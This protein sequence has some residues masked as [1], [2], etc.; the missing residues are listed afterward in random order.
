MQGSEDR[1]ILAIESSLPKPWEVEATF[2][3]TLYEWMSRAP[4]L[5]I[6]GAAHLLLFFLL[7]A[8]P[9]DLLQKREEQVIQTALQPQE[10]IPFEPPP[11]EIPPEIDEEEL[12]DEPVLQDESVEQDDVVEDLDQQLSEGD[13]EDLFS[14]DFDVAE[15]WNDVLGIG[16]GGPPG[17]VRPAGKRPGRRAQGRLLPAGDPGRPAVARGAPVRGR[18]LG[19]RRLQRQLRQARLERVRGRRLQQPRRGR[20]RGWRSWP[21]SA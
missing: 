15:A 4:W 3:D 9:W 7:M 1:R 19:R 21:S 11:E 10:E 2:H 16:G 14:T 8:I 13:P 17:Q 18:L 6:S 12:V 20:D 5:A